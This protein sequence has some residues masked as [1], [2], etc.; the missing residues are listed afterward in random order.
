MRQNMLSVDATE[1][2]PKDEVSPKTRSKASK[3]LPMLTVDNRYTS[4]KTSVTLKKF[5]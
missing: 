4:G 3:S 5:P 1:K 2:N